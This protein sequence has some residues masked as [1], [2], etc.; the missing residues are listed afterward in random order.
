MYYTAGDFG[1]VPNKNKLKGLLASVQ[2]V[3]MW[4]CF[5]SDSKTGECWPSIKTVAKE[6]GVTDRTVT[7]ALKKLEEVGILER[8]RRYK[9]NVEI[10]SIY[11]VVCMGVV[12]SFHD[13]GEIDSYRTITTEL[14]PKN[15]NI[16]NVDLEKNR[17]IDNETINTPFLAKTDN[18]Q[19]SADLTSVSKCVIDRLNEKAGTHYKATSK[20]TKKFI[21]ARLKDG[22]T[23]E[24]MLAVVDAKVKEWGSD[25]VMCKYLRP[26]T[27]FN[28]TK[29]ESYIGLI[30]VAPVEIDWKNATEEQMRHFIKT[31]P[32]AG[33]FKV[34]T[35]NYPLYQRCLNS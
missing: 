29:F 26:E 23:Q 19:S 3:Y 11:K 30:D 14:K 1:I 18:E 6:A 16:Y 8:N 9:D 4:I 12:N 2:S 32:P 28:A 33:H 15:N 20:A 25:S 5:H 17:N 13:G 31:T 10:T 35:T 34:A 7:K 24:D 22:Y 27:L 21:S